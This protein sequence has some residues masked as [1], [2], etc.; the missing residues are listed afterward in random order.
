MNL[1]YP[2]S[3]EFKASEALGKTKEGLRQKKVALCQNKSSAVGT[4]DTGHNSRFSY[5][6]AVTRTR[7]L[8]SNKNDDC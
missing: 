7:F 3:P 4:N 2:A 6:N 5:H 1:C 8:G